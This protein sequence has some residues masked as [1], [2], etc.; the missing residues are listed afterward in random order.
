[1]HLSLPLITT[2]GCSQSP[3]GHKFFISKDSLRE[4]HASRCT[5]STRGDT[6]PEI[7]NL[8]AAIVG[9]TSPLQP[10]IRRFF[11][12]EVIRPQSVARVAVRQRRTTRG[13]PATVRLRHREHLWYVP[14]AASPQQ[15]LSNRVVIVR[16]FVGIAIRRAKAA[17]AGVHADAADNEPQAGRYLL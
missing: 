2:K 11:R 8:R 9:R 1:L 17:A 16:S 5:I 10:L 7:C 14:V 3:E 15:Y 12:N 4:K 6:W 13:A